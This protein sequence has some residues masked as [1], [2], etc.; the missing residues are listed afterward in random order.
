[1]NLPKVRRIYEVSSNKGQMLRVIRISKGENVWVTVGFLNTDKNKIDGGHHI[2]SFSLK[3]FWFYFSETEQ[4]EKVKL[5]ASIK[6]NKT[7]I[8]EIYEKALFQIGHQNS[9]FEMRGKIDF[10]KT[11]EVMDR[12]MTK[13]DMKNIALKALEEVEKLDN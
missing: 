10:K 6:R 11:F 3:D 1:M 13:E 5:T 4:P 8:I 12:L 9:A 7:K 2:Q